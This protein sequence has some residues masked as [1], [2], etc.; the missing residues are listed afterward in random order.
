MNRFIIVIP[1]YNVEQ[2]IKTCLSSVKK[3]IYTNYV[4]I[5][6]DDIS[7][8]KSSNIVQNYIKSDDRFI[9]IKNTEKKYAL[10]NIYDSILIANP[11]DE[12]I[13]VTL[14]G[15]DWFENE[16]VLSVLNSY[17]Q[18]NDCLMTYGSYREFPSNLIGKYSKQIP[19]V[20]ID[21][22]S[23]RNY[24]WCSSHLRSFKYKLWKRIDKNDLL[25][26]DG[27]F[28]RMAGDLSFMFPMLEMAGNRA[29][30]I[31]D[32]LYVYNLDNPF[33]DHKIDNTLQLT[34]EKQIRNKKK[35]D[36]L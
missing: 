34:L 9:F 7:T 27:K 2:W 19:Q 24:E 26:T 20:I 6:T 15:D 21:N 31:N 11:A 4:C 10:K 35:Y 36:L 25:D 18:N 14:D 28:Y 30:Y 22:N 13:I 32:I 5:V 3:Q 17:Y 8:D 12:D 1:F 29:K 23:Y 33:N 16:N